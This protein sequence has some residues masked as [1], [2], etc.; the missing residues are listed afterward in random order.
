MDP[1]VKKVIDDTKD[2]FNYITLKEYRDSA[3]GQDALV[4]V[5]T[6]KPYLLATQYDL[7]PVGKTFVIDHHETDEFSLKTNILM[8]EH[9]VPVK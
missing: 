1:G 4:I 3:K 9:L 7:G 5:D 2:S 8:K 6:N